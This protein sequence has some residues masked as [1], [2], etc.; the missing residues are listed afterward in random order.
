MKA[1]A[2]VHSRHTLWTGWPCEIPSFLHTHDYV[3]VSNDN[4]QSP[5]E[6]L[7][8]CPLRRNSH[9]SLTAWM[10]SACGLLPGGSR[11]LDKRFM[12]SLVSF[13]FHMQIYFQ[14]QVPTAMVR[15]SSVGL[16]DTRICRFGPEV[17]LAQS[18]STDYIRSGNTP[19]LSCGP[20]LA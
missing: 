19:P 6:I 8:P 1:K 20:A 15:V 5:A 16:T 13:R 10:K 17:C 4:G 12:G 3:P 2:K 7:R 14:E 11:L 18:D 9:S